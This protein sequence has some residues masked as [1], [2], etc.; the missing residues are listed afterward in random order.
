[1][2]PHL[3]LAPHNPP[4]LRHLLGSACFPHGYTQT[5][6]STV[7]PHGSTLQ[8]GTTSRW[9]NSCLGD[10]RGPAATSIAGDSG[11]IDDAMSRVVDVGVAILDGIPPTTALEEGTSCRGASA[12]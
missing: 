5:H 11:D 8:Y 12:G 10:D 7:S 4:M 6:C 9:R 1:M 3:V 2:V